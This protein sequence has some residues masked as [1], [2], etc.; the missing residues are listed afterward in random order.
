MGT[1]KSF[2]V[3]VPKELVPEI[4]REAVAQGPSSRASA[5][6]ARMAKL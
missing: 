2:C 4:D 5:L 3:S 6:S 1:T